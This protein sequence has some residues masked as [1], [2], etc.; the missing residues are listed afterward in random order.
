MLRSRG[1]DE[2]V[3]ISS[4]THKSRCKK[5]WA[6]EDRKVL[7]CLNTYRKNTIVK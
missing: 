7:W 6:V 3:K 4:K 2:F 5:Y 1:L